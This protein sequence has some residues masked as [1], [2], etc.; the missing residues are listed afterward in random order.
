MPKI[1][2]INHNAI[3]AKAVKIGIDFTIINEKTVQNVSKAKGLAVPQFKEKV[4]NIP[5]DKRWNAKRIN[6]EVLQGIKRGESMD[7]IADRLFPIIDE[8][9]SYAGLTKEE[10]AS[11]IRKNENSAIRNAR[12]MVTQ[13]E[14][15]GRLDS[16]YELQAA[17]TIL[18]KKWIATADERTREWHLDMDG[19]T[20]DLDEPF[21]DGNGNEIQYPGDPDAS[22]ETVYNCRC[23]ME[24]DILGFTDENGE[25]HYLDKPDRESQHSEAISDEKKRREE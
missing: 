8:K 17:G 3:S 12:T 4:L 7:N 24:D 23:S 18:K 11:V 6:S 15:R 1:Y 9:T 25:T 5:K 2:V 13:A 14:N 16:Y 22:P 19:Q 10:A 21:V 20:V